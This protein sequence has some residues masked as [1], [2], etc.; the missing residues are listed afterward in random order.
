MNKD[1]D[2][3]KLPKWCY[4]NAIKPIRTTEDGTVVL[5]KGEYWEYD[6]GS[7]DENTM[8]TKPEKNNL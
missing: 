6:W 4:E 5:P 2:D 3:F 7:D 1:E 8:L